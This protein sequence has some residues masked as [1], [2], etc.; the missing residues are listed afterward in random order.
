[1]ETLIAFVSGLFGVFV[2]LYLYHKGKE[3]GRYEQ[4]AASARFQ[5]AMK[6]LRETIPTSFSAE[7]KED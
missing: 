2:G 4:E 7:K 5:E 6:M 3:A 1:M